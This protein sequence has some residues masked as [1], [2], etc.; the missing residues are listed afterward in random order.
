M[1]LLSV[2]N[3]SK[4]YGLKVLFNNISFG[5]ATNEKVALV[6]A[7]GSGKTSL[8][9]IIT[10]SDVGSTG[11]VTFNNNSTVAYV[12][13]Q[14]DYTAFETIKDVVYN[15]VTPIVKAIKEYEVALELY[16]TVGDEASEKRYENAQ[17]MMDTLDA[18][19]Y[20][21][22]VQMTLNKLNLLNIDM[23]I[24]T[25]S[26]GQ[27]KRLALA[28][29]LAQKPN[30]LI[31]DEPTNHLDIEMI[32][33]LENYLMTLNCA[34]LIVTHDRYFLDR[35]CNVIIELAD[36]KLYS[37][38]GNYSYFVEKKAE[39]EAMQSAEID[40]AR[41]T[42]FRELEWVRRMPKARTTKSKS[43]LDAFDDIKAVAL[44]RKKE[45]E[46]TILSH[47]SRMG[48]KIMEITDL[49]KAFGVKKIINNFT[50]TFTRGEKLG[51]IG[52]NG[53]GKSTFL[54][55]IM[56][57][58]KQDA[59]TIVHGETIVYGYYEQ[60]GLQLKEDKRAIEVVKDVAEYITQPDGSTLTAASLMNKFLFPPDLQ[61]N[62]VSKLS[63]GEQRRLYMLSVLMK[64]PNFLILDE[65]TNDLDIQ[66]LSTLE[67][68]LVDYS[69]CCI[70][71]T[72]DRYFMDRL[73]D[74]LLV[75]KGNGEVE[76]F[77]GNYTQYREYLEIQEEIEK[78]E[79]NKNKKEGN[80]QTTTA[81]AK[82]KI[83]F[84]EKQELDQL[85]LD[86]EALELHKKQLEHEI[87][88]GDLSA[89]LLTKKS[90]EFQT[91]TYSLETKTVRWLELS[92][93]L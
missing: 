38:K 14:P 35:V 2:E 54:N 83:S 62:F 65:P 69:G 93:L 57:M 51:I 77:P 42:Y 82:S 12:S 78:Y 61:H 71:V 43:R 30:L 9:N 50:H 58:E 66:T 11:R 87:A 45:Q 91:T 40:K 41:N 25:L 18:W 32:E 22:Q 73:V 88:Q 72:H 10:G 33:W 46:L 17:A 44:S 28:L 68:F 34:L 48:S 1:N 60:K 86:L 27:V 85:E 37:Y 31:L 8:L 23:P 55:M 19:T 80:L 56:D 59:G 92:E 52:A 84:K 20:E 63:G 36:N 75:F 3:L 90:K 15:P 64:N 21:E 16:S 70:V 26:G 13:Q 6:A 29:A 5:V 89:E 24:K 74:Q 76:L 4:S 47:M 67:N 49:Q 7:N 53:T 79:T 39:R 81:G